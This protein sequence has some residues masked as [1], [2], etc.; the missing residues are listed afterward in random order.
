MNISAHFGRTL[1][2]RSITDSTAVLPDGPGLGPRG[3]GDGLGLRRR[4]VR[5]ALVRDRP[6]DPGTRIRR[7]GEFSPRVERA[8]DRPILGRGSGGCLG[9]GS[10]E[11][12]LARRGGRWDKLRRPS[13]LLSTTSTPRID[14]RLGTDRRCRPSRSLR[15]G[16]IARHGRVRPATLAVLGLL[17]ASVAGRPASGNL[18]RPIRP[19]PR[20]RSTAA[21]VHRRAQPERRADREP[22]GRAL[23]HRH[24]RPDDEGRGRRQARHGAA[25]E[26]QARPLGTARGTGGRHRLERRGVLVL[27]QG[28]D[29][30]TR[31]ST[32][33]TTTRRGRARWPPPS[34]PTGSSRR[35]ASASSPRTRPARSRSARARPPTRSSSPTARRRSAGRDGHARDDRLRVDPAGSASTSLLGRGARRRC[36]PRPSIKDY[37]KVA[38]RR[39]RRHDEP[40]LPPAQAQARMDPREALRWT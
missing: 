2:G 32:S 34:S 14:V 17:A 35:S 27:G 24:D 9:V 16:R 1:G 7:P 5:P 39:A 3:P 13:R 23:D 21:R 29:A 10:R 15:P 11:S 30:R 8:G 26:L 31:R 20:R 38:P 6:E 25:R 40:V 12:E 19:C 22:R 28:H 33:A 36:S 18:A 37:L 4:G